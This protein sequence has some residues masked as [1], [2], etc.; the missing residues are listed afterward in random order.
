MGSYITE[1]DVQNYGTELI[2]LTQ[3]AA[4]QALTPHL[5]NLSQQNAELQ[6]RLAQ[7]A[8]RDLD[9]RVAQAVPD[10]QQIDRDP[11]WHQWLLTP[12][13][14]S[15]KLRQELLNDAIASSDLNRVVSFFRGFQQEAGAG[16]DQAAQQPR[17][18]RMP[19][20]GPDR[21]IYS[22][23]EIAKLY[24]QHLQR[25]RSRVGPPGGGHHRGRP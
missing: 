22:R 20:W 7:E 2:D 17:S 13:P 11:R 1:Q 5:Q 6:Q 9:Q 18:R 16:T 4:V 8:R 25:P 10:Y 14:L 19:M 24:R 21:R 23:A 12:D 15:G 3:R